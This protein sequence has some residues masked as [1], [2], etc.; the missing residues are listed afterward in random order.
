MALID[1][2]F[3][4]NICRRSFL[5]ALGAVETVDSQIVLSGQAGTT[6]DTRGKFVIDIEVDSSSYS[7]E[8]HS[9]SNEAIVC[10]LIIGRTLFQISAELKVGPGHVEINSVNPEILQVMAI[11][12][13]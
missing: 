10:D 3:A 1:T 8:V 6:F 12:V 2:G 7:T 13:D 11:E 5:E 9:V 4:L